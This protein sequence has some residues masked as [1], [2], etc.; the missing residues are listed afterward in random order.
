MFQNFV[1]FQCNTVGNPPNAEIGRNEVISKPSE[2]ASEDFISFLRGSYH[3]NPY[4][5]NGP[6][7]EVQID[8]E[9]NSA[10]IMNDGSRA[11]AESHV[12]MHHNR[13]DHNANPLGGIPS[14]TEFKCGLITEADQDNEYQL[15]LKKV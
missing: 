1:F 8:G 7:G 15:Y 2:S 5:G 9:D 4:D 11:A 12:Y 3:P 14:N 10:Q 6:G 13:N